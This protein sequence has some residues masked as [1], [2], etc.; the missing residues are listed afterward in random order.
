MKSF[1]RV[2]VCFDIQSESTTMKRRCYWNAGLSLTTSS[3][4]NPPLQ[5]LWWL[6]VQAGASQ[7]SLIS[8]APFIYFA[9]ES[10]V[11]DADMTSYLN[12]YTVPVS[13]PL[14]KNVPVRWAHWKKLAITVQTASVTIFMSD[15]PQS[16]L[17]PQARVCDEVAPLKRSPKILEVTLY[18]Y[19]TFGL[20]V[21]WA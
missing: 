21:E 20:H 7:K 9:S 17:P 5:T 13:A 3:S 19:L 10:S 14:I 1:G 12:D 6:V 15:T 8:P 2:S 11:P 4:T 18:T 16:W